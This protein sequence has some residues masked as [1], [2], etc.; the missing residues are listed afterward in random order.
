MAI[1]EVDFQS[2]QVRAVGVMEVRKGDYASV[3]EH[4]GLGMT[5]DVRRYQSLTGRGDLGKATS[6]HG[7][8]LETAHEG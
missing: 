6:Y 8:P 3:K 4:G 7:R 2:E 1:C 5:I